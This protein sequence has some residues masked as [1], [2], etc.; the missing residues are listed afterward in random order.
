MTL[1]ILGGELLRALD[2]LGV[3]HQDD[4]PTVRGKIGEIDASARADAK[5][6]PRLLGLSTPTALSDHIRSSP[7][8]VLDSD[9]LP[10]SAG[11]S[12]GGLAG[13]DPA[14]CVATQNFAGV[15]DAWSQ[16]GGACDGP[17]AA[18]VEYDTPV[19][20]PPA[21]AKMAHGSCWE[22]AC[23]GR[24]PGD[25]PHKQAPTLNGTAIAEDF[26]FG[27]DALRPAKPFDVASIEERARAGRDL[28]ASLASAH[29]TSGLLEVEEVVYNSPRRENQAAATIANLRW[30]AQMLGCGARW[31][32]LD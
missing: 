23:F 2:K 19:H 11:S 14:S 16:G 31:T 28:R 10:N 13:S 1:P 12:G 25:R 7:T 20:R 32:E 24:A 27:H 29:T 3:D 5:Q 9:A 21:C 17:E 22:E 30:Y 4:T 18:V 15:G 26:A 6:Y 8:G